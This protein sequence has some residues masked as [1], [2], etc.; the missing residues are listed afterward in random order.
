MEGMVGELGGE[1]RLDFVGRCRRARFVRLSRVLGE[2]SAV[3]GIISIVR[4]D[5]F[6]F[7][8]VVILLVC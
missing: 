8:I 6:S 3:F 5:A 1:R 4:L 2:S 7:L